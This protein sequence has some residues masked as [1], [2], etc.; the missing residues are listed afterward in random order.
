MDHEHQGQ[1]P[2]VTISFN[3][4]QMLLRARLWAQSKRV[5]E[6]AE[7]PLR[8]GE[9]SRPQ[10]EPTQHRLQRSALLILGSVGASIYF[11]SDRNSLQSSFIRSPSSRHFPRRSRRVAGPYASRQDLGIVAHCTGAFAIKPAVNAMRQR[12]GL[13]DH[14]KRPSS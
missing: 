8:T 3:L 6:S 10:S 4:A 1:F 13:V 11:A 2:V 9:L 5:T 7:R 12:R 14:D